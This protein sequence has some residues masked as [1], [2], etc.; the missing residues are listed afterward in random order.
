[1]PEES[2]KA[3]ARGNR[4]HA[5]GGATQKLRNTALP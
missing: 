2:S 1:M 5:L 3:C 4:S